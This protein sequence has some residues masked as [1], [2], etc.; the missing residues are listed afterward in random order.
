MTITE[1]ALAD[2]LLN[3]F[4]TLEPVAQDAIVKNEMKKVAQP[5]GST[6]IQ[7]VPTKGDVYLPKDL[8]N[9]MS[10]AIAKA[11]WPQLGGIKIYRKTT[12][13]LT[14]SGTL[15]PS[16]PTFISAI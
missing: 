9:A 5:D 6:K 12:T 15:S 1:Q 3:Y 10:K 16:A 14:V 7:M 2:L 4:T 13:S 8:S 11:I